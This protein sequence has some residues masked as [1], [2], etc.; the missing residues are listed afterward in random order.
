MEEGLLM[1][2]TVCDKCRFGVT[3][4][5]VELLVAV[6]EKSPQLFLHSPSQKSVGDGASG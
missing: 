3:K 2:L 5:V 4:A 6:I 1:R